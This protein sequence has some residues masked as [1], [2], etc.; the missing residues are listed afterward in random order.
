MRRIL[1]VLVAGA[2]G[3]SCSDP[4]GPPT[5]PA[6]VAVFA[7]D[8]QTAAVG[9]PVP[10]RP[11]VRVT[12]SGGEPIARASVRFEVIAGG[13]SVAGSPGTTNASGVAT[14]QSWTLGDA[15]G[16]N[17]LSARVG[18]LPPVT[19]TATGTPGFDIQLRYLTTA[20][21]PQRQA[22][23]DAAARWE[24]LAIGDLPDANLS[25]RSGECGS[26]S[27]PVIE[28]VDDILILVSL[29]AVDGPGGVLAQ[30]GPC[31]VRLTND[32]PILG[33]M[34]V[35]SDDLAALEIYGLLSD[36]V[37]H[38]MGHVLGFGTLWT[39]HGLLADPSES[40]GLDPHFT[41]PAAIDA[42]ND[43][44]GASYAGAKVPVEDTGG[45]GT[46][47]AHWRES[48]LGT[49]LMTGFLEVGQPNPLSFITV[50]SLADQGYNVNTAAADMFTVGAV[51]GAVSDAEPVAIALVDD[52][53]RGTVYGIDAAGLVRTVRRR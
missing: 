46:A 14:V 12:G 31:F 9:T 4:A 39:T 28:I 25:A 18:S 27:P 47:D 30:S 11:A 40:G 45:P 29:E 44:G 42:F 17:E 6:N 23:S 15:L 38:E 24:A 2:L 8:G 41:G 7:G 43:A 5:S 1:C 3:A 51:A 35:D 26:N 50:A 49:E 10:I 21:N 52:I 32:L 48:V 16:V 34:R 19:I 37:L 36:V 22:F 20:T 13:G 53:R 33:Q